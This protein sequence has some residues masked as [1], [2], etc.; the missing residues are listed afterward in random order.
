MSMTIKEWTI[1]KP[2]SVGMYLRQNPTV[3]GRSCIRQAVI[4]DGGFL[5]TPFG[6]AGALKK[7]SDLPD[8]FLWFG[9][10]PYPDYELR[11]KAMK[12]LTG[13]SREAVLKSFAGQ[14][15]PEA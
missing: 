2:A 6:D 4:L 10:I 12:I 5:W 7:I 13:K 1:D 8:G 9:P 15:N 11:V 14:Q 3:F